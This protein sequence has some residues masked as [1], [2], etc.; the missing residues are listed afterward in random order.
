MEDDLRNE[1]LILKKVLYHFRLIPDSR[2]IKALKKEMALFAEWEKRRR[3]S[4]LTDEEKINAFRSE[5]AGNSTAAYD[6]NFPA[7]AAQA[8]LIASGRKTIRHLIPEKRR[9]TPL[10]L[11]R[12]ESEGIWEDDPPKLKRYFALY[13]EYRKERDRWNI[14]IPNKL[15]KKLGKLF[16]S[17]ESDKYL[18]ELS[19]LIES[20]MKNQP[21]EVLSELLQ[22]DKDRVKLLERMAK[23]WEE[24]GLGIRFPEKHP[25]G[26][27]FLTCNV[28]ARLYGMRLEFLETI[29]SRISTKKV[30]Q[31]FAKLKASM[32][33][34]NLETEIIGDR[35]SV[36]TPVINLLSKQ[37]AWEMGNLENYLKK[38]FKNFWIKFEKAEREERK[39]AER[40][41]LQTDFG[42][43]DKEGKRIEDEV[44][45]FEESIDYQEKAI[46]P[47]KEMEGKVNLR[48]VLSSLP[49]EQREMALMITDDLP[50][51]EIA[52][53][54]GVDVRT[55]KRWFHEIQSNQSFHR[56]LKKGLEE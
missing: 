14:P 23:P 48:M 27:Y 55:I 16:D 12:V 34:S 41:I 3:H 24:G 19:N 10:D 46:A 36:Y 2:M 51:K 40:E 26:V 15:F 13:E 54:F 11:A 56:L 22:P 4:S 17:G 25:F 33:L 47:S 20:W 7:A 31:A 28:I 1:E 50:Q 44:V 53:K 43:T 45:L 35:L 32:K 37:A 49:P 42:K 29:F 9:L 5:R 38:S 8:Y 30:S 6:V 18:D 21:P 39:R 52:K